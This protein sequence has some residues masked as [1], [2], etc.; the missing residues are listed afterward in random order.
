MYQDDWDP[1]K[2]RLSTGWGLY[3]LQVEGEERDLS[4]SF[5]FDFCSHRGVD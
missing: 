3:R 5:V 4:F 2:I 1:E